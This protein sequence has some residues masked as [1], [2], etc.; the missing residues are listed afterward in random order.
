MC[1]KTKIFFIFVK[2]E[3]SAGKSSLI[4]LLLEDELLPYHLLNTTSTIC[5]MKYGKERKIVVHY[6]Y[7]RDQQTKLQP[8][9]I[10]LEPE[11]E[12]KS[13]QDQI[14]PFVSQ[15]QG[16]RE[17]GSEY[18]KVEIFWPHKLLEV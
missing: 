11:E 15:K 14:E 9:T 10:P 1:Y 18:L 5:E 17:K 16:D 13:Y 8:K 12:G 6:G 2:G 3:C 4:N 7:D